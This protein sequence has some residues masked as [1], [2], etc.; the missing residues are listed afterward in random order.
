M[1]DRHW[2]LPCEPTGRA[3]ATHCR[4]FI[5]LLFAAR[6]LSSVLGGQAQLCYDWRMTCKARD[7]A[8]CTA[9][10]LSGRAVACEAKGQHDRAL[11]LR[12]EAWPHVRQGY[13]ADSPEQ[14]TA[15]RQLLDAYHDLGRKEPRLTLAEGELTRAR[16][17][18]PRDHPHVGMMLI[19]VSN[20]CRYQDHDLPR[21]QLC[22]EEA[23][24]IFRASL[25]ECTSSLGFTLH[26]QGAV[27]CRQGHMD[28]AISLLEEALE[29]RRRALPAGKLALAETL[30]LLGRALLL[31]DQQ[32]GQ[33]LVEEALQWLQQEAPRDPQILYVLI[34][35][36]RVHV[37]A[38]AGEPA[39]GQALAC[40]EKALQL[41]PDL[42]PLDDQFAG[43]AMITLAEV[44]VK[45]GDHKRAAEVA[46]EARARSRVAGNVREVEA[47]LQQVVGVVP[48]EAKG[49]GG[50]QPRGG[51]AKA[52][53]EDEGDADECT[54]DALEAA[55][56][57]AGGGGGK[58]SKRKQRRKKQWGQK[59]SG[60]GEDEDAQDEG[61][62]GAEQREDEGGG[63]AQAAGL[64]D[65][66]QVRGGPR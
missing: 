65:E 63:G 37:K 22:L 52:G 31:T 38:G 9:S 4:F 7:E 33:A 11:A 14:R 3:I 6:A 36:S 61:Q 8:R 2:C 41:L 17:I 46:G 15:L 27:A 59:P 49:E 24:G 13:P 26:Q 34:T 39:K 44:L 21:A 18:F 12:E 51:G 16:G 1:K 32:R 55:A 40:V 20:A 66:V 64:I 23:A 50:V 35:L 5:L 42:L 60:G 53:D 25:P 56:R 28:Q 58:S 29:T 10:S 43:L 19:A 45:L 62:D 48:D 54:K 57:K 30:N 47:L